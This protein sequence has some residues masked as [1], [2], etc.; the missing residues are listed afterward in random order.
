MQL[1]DYD[2]SN[3]IQATVTANRLITPANAKEEVHQIDLELAEGARLDAVVGRSIGVL[4]PGPDEYGNP[5]HFRLYSIAG[6][7]Q[8]DKGTIIE[9]CVRRCFYIDEFSGEQYK[10]KASNY[11]CDRKQ[12]D[13]ITITGSYGVAFTLP[14]DASSNLLMVGVGTGIAPFRAFTKAIYAKKGAWTGKVR[15]FYGARRGVEL[16]YM[17]DVKNDF[18]LYYDEATFKAFEALSSRPALDKDVTIERTIDQNSDEVWAMV[19]DPKTFVYIAGL[20]KMA[21][22]LDKVFSKMAGSEAHWAKMKARLVQDGRWAELL[23]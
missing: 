17:N 22:N 13:A 1:K 4:V 20:Q 19:Q 2:I 3:Q 12:G 21:G 18:H 7:H 14:T 6:S 15:L 9:I 8:G 10:G 5:H 16:L 23:Y 11:L